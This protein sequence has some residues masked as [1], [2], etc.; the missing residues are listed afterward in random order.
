MMTGRMTD[1]AG[2]NCNSEKMKK[3]SEQAREKAETPDLLAVARGIDPGAG[4]LISIKDLR[5]AA[6]MGKTEFDTEIMRLGQNGKIFLHRHVHPGR[7]NDAEKAD[8][9][10]C[11]NCDPVELRKFSP[12]G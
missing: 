2:L 1:R 7:M 9:V 3:D 12:E 6:G 5:A 11:D 8:C 4:H 10:E